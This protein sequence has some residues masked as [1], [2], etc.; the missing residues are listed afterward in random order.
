M[1]RRSMRMDIVVHGFRTVDKFGR[2]MMIVADMTDL[3]IMEDIDEDVSLNLIEGGEQ[4]KN[5][6]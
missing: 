5:T 3:L 2:H 4:S 1:L 6:S